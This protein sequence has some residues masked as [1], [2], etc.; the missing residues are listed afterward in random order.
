VVTH[1][2]IRMDLQRKSLVRLFQTVQKILVIFDIVEDLLPTSP[3]I[4]DVII[5]TL[6]FY[7]LWS[8]HVDRIGICISYVKI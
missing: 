4:H 3:S 5:R 8:R 7:P 6:I 1:Q 2:T